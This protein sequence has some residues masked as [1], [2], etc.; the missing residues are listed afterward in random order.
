[1]SN[2]SFLYTD[3]PQRNAIVVLPLGAWEQHGLHLPI[4]TDSII[5][6]AVVQTTLQEI[7]ETSRYV[8]APTLAI[9]ASDEHRGFSGTLSTGTEAL[10]QS[11]VAICRSASWARGVCIANGHG[12]N[13]DA[14][15]LIT[16]ALQY[17]GITHSIWSLP[18]YKG[19]DMHAGHT[20]TS[21]LLHLHPESVRTDQ[22]QAGNPGAPS[23]L[24][25]SMRTGG[26]ISVSENG[27]L[28]DPTIATAAHGKEVF[29]MYTNSLASHLGSV[30]SA[31]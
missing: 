22:I 30:C 29:N 20:E 10:V 18:S 31:W 3:S 27:V 19:G 6:E 25:E 17:E 2:Q 11:V 16:S 28:G 5:I 14:L 8:L 26:V 9:T 7:P 12:G 1:M 13:S 4:N 21:L 24:V 23:E 15:Q